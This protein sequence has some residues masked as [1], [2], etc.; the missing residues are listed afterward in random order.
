LVTG[1]IL[2]V[3]LT[4]P[5][6]QR[7]VEPVFSKGVLAR[8]SPDGRS[9]VVTVDS[10]LYVSPYPPPA[11]ESLSEVASLASRVWPFFSRDGRQ[12]YAVTDE[13]IYSYPVSNQPAGGIRLGDRSMLFKLHDPR[14]SDANPAAATRNGQRILAIAVDRDEET[15]LQ[16]LSD[17]TT[18]LK[19]REEEK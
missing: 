19:K 14:R 4:K 2:R 11:A 13:T 18:L 17:W 1:G 12:L 3:D 5:R 6:A 8:V 9:I 15:K 16:V 7:R 10:R